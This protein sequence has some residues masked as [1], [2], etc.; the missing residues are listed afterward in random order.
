[1]NEQPFF[2]VIV[3]LHN[4]AEFMHKGLRSILNQTFKDYELLCLCDRCEDNTVAIAREYCDVV[5]SVDFGRASL[6]R[7]VGLDIAQGKWILFMDDDDWF[8]HPYAFE[9]LHNILESATCDVLAFGF[10]CDWQDGQGL[11]AMSFLHPSQQSVWVA[12]WTKAW[13]RDFIGEHRFPD[14]KHSDDLGFAQ[15][16]FPLVK[17]WGYAN[18]QLYYYNYMRPGSIQ[19]KLRTGE[20]TMDDM[21]EGSGA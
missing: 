11:Q 18:L 14:W 5:L 21:K 4:S 1:M 17:Q 10:L 7:N 16:M 12:P 2:S 6:T 15:E 3:P 8:V 20:L 19:D 13:R 9:L